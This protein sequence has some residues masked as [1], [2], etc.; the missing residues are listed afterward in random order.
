VNE[1][2]TN[3][4]IQG[5]LASSN[6][7]AINGILPIS[8]V[9]DWFK[10]ARKH[11]PNALLFLNEFAILDNINPSKQKNTLA[12]LKDI[13]KRGGP[14]D[15]IGFQGHFGAS[16]P[17]FKD[18]QNV[19]NDFSPLVKT[20]SLTEFD[21]ETLDPKLQADVT[22]DL[23][24]FIYSQPKFNLFQMWGFW[25]ADHWLGSAP[26]FTRD[27]QLK[28]SGAVWQNLTQNTWR[29]RS[30]G[31]TNTQG[32]LETIAFY[33]TY[34]VTISKAGKKCEDVVKFETPG[35]VVVKAHC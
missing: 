9:A 32:Q 1:P 29:T 31:T 25:D 18:M 28:P 21:F 6:V 13:Q 7:K 5:R 15:G 35:E 26:L 30:N 20:M 4:D 14:V 3:T 33:G 19:I 23:M 27:W 24:T 10:S 11:D 17:V 2:F 16:G 12:L 8:S 22:E 34:V